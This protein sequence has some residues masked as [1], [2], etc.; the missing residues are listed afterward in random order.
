MS[1][2]AQAT[3]TVYHQIPVDASYEQAK[4]EVDNVKPARIP[5]LRL[6]IR[7]LSSAG[8]KAFLS[9]N[10]CDS[11]LEKAVIGV[12]NL[13]YTS[14]STLPTTRSVTLVL[15]DI[16]GVAYTTGL[17]LDDDH[18]E[19]HFSTKHIERV[20]GEHREKEI[21]GVIRHEMVHCW[22][23]NAKG[24]CPGGLIE[25]IADFVRLRGDLGPPHWKHSWRDCEWDAGYERTAYFLDYLERRFG[26]GTVIR[27]N[28][29][30]RDREYDECSFW[31]HCCGLE[32][33]TLWS[34]YCKH[35]DEKY[36]QDPEKD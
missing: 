19:I 24:T 2:P 15:R 5:K 32:I 34:D 33:S 12:L 7:D 16:D 13:L 31:I 26:Y 6:E 30:L 1:R 36:P 22:Q 18:K 21:I 4:R 28:E 27:I 8:A 14:Q 29:R 23:W 20:S 17:D 25:G 9:I 3:P 35:C 11:I 10:G